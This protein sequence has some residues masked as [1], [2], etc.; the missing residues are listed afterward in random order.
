MAL[1]N[2]QV[3]ELLLKLEAD[4]I[5]YFDTLART[6]EQ[7][8]QTLTTFA[9]IPSTSNRILDRPPIRSPTSTTAPQDVDSYKKGST[10]TGDDDDSSIDDD[11]ESLFV[12]QPLPPDFY[13]EA[14]L[15]EH[16]RN[17]KWDQFGKKILDSLVDIGP[18]LENGNINLFP[19]VEGPVE[20]RSHLTHHQNF[21][22]GAD[23]APLLVRKADENA[24][25]ALKFWK[26]AKSLNADPK[27]QRQAVGR[28]TQVALPYIEL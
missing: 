14:G 17:Y 6:Q 2:A 11:N 19:A 4:R 28:I 3:K 5:A 10:F 27:T 16:I 26:N 22:I 25:N 23:G 8:S 9:N 1:D 21:D 24:S 12:Q 18:H 15:C 20:D 7:L 13:D